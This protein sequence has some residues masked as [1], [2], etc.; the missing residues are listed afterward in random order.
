[1]IIISGILILFGL[2][3]SSI[4]NYLLFHSIA[5][6]FS[7][8][9]AC[10]IFIIA[11]NSRRFLDSNYLLF[12][13]IAYL[14]IAVLDLLHTLSYT[15]MGIFKGYGTNL[16]TQLWIAARFMESLSLLI[17]PLFF[18]RAIRIRLI[19]AIYIVAFFFLVGSVFWNI[20]PSCFVEGT[21]L[22]L[23]KKSSE[24][25][26]SL[27]LFGSIF[28]LFQKRKRLETGVFRLIV[29]SILVTVGSEFALTFYVH[30]YGFSNLVGHYFKIISFYLIYKAIIETGLVKPYSL[31][32]RNLWQSEEALRESDERYRAIFNQA[33]DSILIVDGETGALVEFNENAHKNLGYT[34]EEF[35]KIKIQDFEVVE[36]EEEVARHIRKIIIEGTDSF[37]TKQRTKG[38]EIRNIHVSA[39]AISIQ[40]KIFIQSIWRDI[41]DHKQAEEALLES[42]KRYRAVLETAADPLIVYDNTG[43]MLY[44]N[45]AF[46][47]TFG[48]TFEELFDKKI[49]FVPDE[50]LDEANRAIKKCY[51][52]GYYRFETR[53]Y[54]KKK[55][56]LD[57]S[58]GGAI[59]RD[60]QGELQGMVVNLK[61]ITERK[62]TETQIKAS[63]KEKEILL[64]EI[65][66]R[67]KNNMQV[68]SSLLK[69]QAFKVGDERVTDALM[70]FRGRVQAMAFVHETL[71]GSDTLADIDFKTYISKVANQVFQ[72][73]KTS[74]DRIKLKVDAKDIKLGIEQ[75]VPLGLIT[76]ELLTN[77]L[78]YAFPENRSGEIVI[79]IRPVEQD[80]IEF[81]FSD[82]GIGIPEGMDWRNTDSLGLR[83]VIILTDQ[84]DGA[85]SLD[86]GKSTHFIV[87]FRHKK[88]Q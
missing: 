32:F 10:S 52:D 36:S 34:R 76:N 63:L 62:Q 26:I 77:S 5:E 87:K 58:L 56:I 48:W 17:A 64:Q 23:F 59:W 45:P 79:S 25:I 74:M 31:L 24:Y 80:S 29:A 15:G 81:V 44:I 86:R 66:H 42:E 67:V 22:T 49:P 47:S 55:N 73:F 33:A 82:N 11:W 70:E 3:L 85:L 69:L 19:F 75:A 20:F 30:A 37:E 50:Y 65:H 9:I 83:L 71:Y 8:I 41:T 54:D 28:L 2:Y 13:G 51:S 78:K 39:R 38:G 16:P 18:E 61:D 12:L 88:N 21:G 35:A 1:M 4:Y 7:I 72:T 68:I 27:I 6:I 60:P 84:L 43:K 57:V 46:T 40:E 53:R 14:F